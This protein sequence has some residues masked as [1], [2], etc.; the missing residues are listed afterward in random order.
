M[1]YLAAKAHSSRFV[2]VLCVYAWASYYSW[3][4]DNCEQ[5]TNGLTQNMDSDYYSI[6]KVVIL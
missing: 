1:Q 2:C 5:Y 3:A 4:A 6:T